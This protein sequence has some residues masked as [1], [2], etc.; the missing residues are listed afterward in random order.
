[1]WD[2]LVKFSTWAE[3]NSGQI[4]ILIAFGAIWLAWEAYKKTLDQMEESKSQTQHFAE[5]VAEAAKQTQF[6]AKQFENSNI[7]IQELIDHRNLVLGIRNGELKSDYIDLGIKTILACQNNISATGQVVHSLEVFLSKFMFDE[8]AKENI[9]FNIERMK[10][11]IVQSEENINKLMMMSADLL[12]E[13]KLISNEMLQRDIYTIN[14]IYLMELR[15]KYSNENYR[16]GV[17]KVIGTAS[18]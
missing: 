1:M 12:D 2:C 7:Q 17:Q 3:N 8:E 16:A 5:Q 14:L 6:A 13:T 11:E 15:N 10:K 9:K 18:M 4:Q